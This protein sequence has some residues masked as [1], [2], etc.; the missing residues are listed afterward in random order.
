M[1]KAELARVVFD[2]AKLAGVNFSF[3]NLARA[4]LTGLDLAGA[5][6]TGAYLFLT[7][8]GG[9]DLSRASGLTQAQL[10]LA[11]GTDQTKLPQGLNRPKAWPCGDDDE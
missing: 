4:R 11:C 7:Q 5:N 8:I 10:D 2:K 1:S 9:A 6:L 3:S